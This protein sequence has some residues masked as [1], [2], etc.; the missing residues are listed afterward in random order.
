MPTLFLV[1]NHLHDSDQLLEHRVYESYND[2]LKAKRHACLAYDCLDSALEVVSMEV[3]SHGDA[4]NEVVSVDRVFF[5]K[6][7]KALQE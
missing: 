1:L 5:D 4:I 7:K 2:A 6:L 3:V